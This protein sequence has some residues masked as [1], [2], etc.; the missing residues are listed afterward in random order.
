MLYK[1]TKIIMIFIMLTTQMGESF[2]LSFM[3]CADSGMMVMND[4]NMVH[5]THSMAMDNSS[6]TSDED[7]C[8]K[9]C[10]CPMGLM[11]VAV[12]NEPNI[13]TP[14]DCRTTQLIMSHST[15]HNIFL[16]LPQR[17]PKTTFS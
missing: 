13:D 2:A 1:I 3:P 8:Q 7:C 15:I 12:P 9:D 16:G 10:C 5:S 4:K 17:P 6:M 14:I 11:T